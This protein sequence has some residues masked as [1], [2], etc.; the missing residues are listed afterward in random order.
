MFTDSITITVLV[1]KKLTVTREE[2]EA[3]HLNST[4]GDPTGTRVTFERDFHG[5]GTT[6]DV[7]ESPEELKRLVH[8]P[9]K[10]QV[11]AEQADI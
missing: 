2:F 5:L 7:R 9:P 3:A 6:I 8:P 4:F 1:E 11:D 10:S